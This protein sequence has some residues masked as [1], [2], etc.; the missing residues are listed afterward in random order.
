MARH[1]VIVG[2]GLAGL[3]TAY[4]LLG[5]VDRV[6]VIEQDHYPHQ[7]EFGVGIPQGR[8]V[9]VLIAGGQLILDELLPGIV[10]ALRSA[11]ARELVLPRDM[12]VYTR[13]GWHHRFPQGRFSLVSCTRPTLD[14]VV[15]GRVLAAAEASPTDV[16]V[17]QGAQVTGLLGTSSR[18]AGV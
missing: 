14:H 10:A 4:T 5:H 3:L 13:T 15:R 1:V 8:H 7:P 2:G 9:H 16:E 12:L 17:L 11:G 6:T 18:A